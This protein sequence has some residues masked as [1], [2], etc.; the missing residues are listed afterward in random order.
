MRTLSG[1]EGLLESFLGIC[2]ASVPVFAAPPCTVGT[3]DQLPDLTSW[4]TP[5]AAVCVRIVGGLRERL[6]IC[7]ETDT[8]YKTDLPIIISN[9]P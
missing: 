5:R 8:G 1:K 7:R 3:K 9:Q 4:R 6:Q 2:T